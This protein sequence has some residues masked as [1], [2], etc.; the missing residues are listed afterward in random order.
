MCRAITAHIN[1]IKY[2]VFYSFLSFCITFSVIFIFSDVFFQYAVYP[3]V[4]LGTERL[5]FTQITEAFT[6]SLWLS[7][8]ISFVL[9]LPFWVYQVLCFFAPGWTPQER[10]YALIWSSIWLICFSLGLVGAYWFFPIVWKFFLG[11]GISQNSG[12]GLKLEAE[13]RVLPYLTSLIWLTLFISILFQIPFWASVACHFNMIESKTLVD[14]RRIIW[15]LSILVGALISP[16]DIF[17]QFFI[18]FCFAVIYELIIFISF[19]F[20]VYRMDDTT[21]TNSTVRS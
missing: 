10:Q 16:P 2:R 9:N 6:A 5:I 21:V 13:L 18:A 19:S 8:G 1:E 4:G 14:N 20:E 11:Y 12:F 15:F 7:F 17:S 3:L